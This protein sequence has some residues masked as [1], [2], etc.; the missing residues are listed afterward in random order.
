MV[1]SPVFEPPSLDGIENEKGGNELEPL[2]L[3]S[4]DGFLSLDGRAGTTR[5]SGKGKFVRQRW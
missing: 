1:S 5:L 2:L 3:E 4:D